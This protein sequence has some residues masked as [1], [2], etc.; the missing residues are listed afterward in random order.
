LNLGV[1]REQTSQTIATKMV[2]DHHKTTAFLE[3][4]DKRSCPKSEVNGDEGTGVKGRKLK[5]LGQRKP[6]WGKPH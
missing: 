4:Q 6:P 2:T 1:S 3:K 5:P